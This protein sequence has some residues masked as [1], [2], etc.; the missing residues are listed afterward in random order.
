[1]LW[2]DY[3]SVPQWEEEIKLPIL[4]IIPDIFHRA[5]YT[6]VHLHDVDE[7]M[8]YRLQS[9]TS[10]ERIDAITGICNATWFGRV[11]T[12][13]EYVRSQDTKIMTKDFRIVQE[14]VLLEDI[15]RVWNEERARLGSIHALEALAQMGKNLVPWNLGPLREG[16]MLERLDFGNAFSL[17]SRRGCR[18]SR[19]FFHALAGVVKGKLTEPLKTD[20]PEKAIIQIA[21]ACLRAGDYSPLLMVPRTVSSSFAGFLSGCGYQDALSFGLSTGSGF[22][23]HH[24]DSRFEEDVSTLKLERIGTV[25]YTFLGGG[26][27]HGHIAPFLSLARVTLFFT[28]PDVEAFVKTVGPRLYNLR[29]DV[30]EAVLS[31]PDKCAKLSELLQRLH[32]LPEREFWTDKDY[33]TAEQVARLTGILDTYP[34]HP[35]VSPF[36]FTWEHGATMHGLKPASLMAAKCA[37]CR[38]IFVYRVG[39]H[40]PPHKVHGAVAYRITGWQHGMARK[41]GLGILVKDGEIVGR[42]IWASRACA[43][44]ET[45]MVRISLR[46]LP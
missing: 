35:M 9:L 21:T 15:N 8:I 40:R 5:K 41:D 1:E 39:F 3:I 29:D 10:A 20:Y 44:R 25:T 37:S 42:L 36:D 11:W 2:F 27:R 43:C 31:H 24:A 16:R 28:G 22:P 45:D 13:M 18:S 26:Y 38:E 30:V 17:L 46:D 33:A 32:Q 34:G 23:D 6:L 14:D 12:A 19:D 7:W 4:R